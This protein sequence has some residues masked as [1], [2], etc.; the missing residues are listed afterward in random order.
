M[1][2]GIQLTLEFP[3]FFLPKKFFQL[4]Y[5]HQKE[6]QFAQTAAVWAILDSYLKAFAGQLSKCACYKI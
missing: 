2:W 4:F 6:K 1:T 5:R 3:E